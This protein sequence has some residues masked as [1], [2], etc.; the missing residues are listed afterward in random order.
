MISRKNAFYHWLMSVPSTLTIP[1]LIRTRWCSGWSL[2][3]CCG[4]IQECRGPRTG[5]SINSFLEGK[6]L[7]KVQMS[8]KRSLIWIASNSQAW[9]KGF[10]FFWVDWQVL[11][12]C[13]DKLE[14]KIN[15]IMLSERI[16]GGIKTHVFASS[17]VC[18]IQMKEQIWRQKSGGIASTIR[19][20]FKKKSWQFEHFKYHTQ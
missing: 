7:L 8:C 1:H 18:L 15:L 19:T 12:H 9:S 20:N 11:T 10:F 5:C 4:S 2:Q 14:K 16:L 17:F 6:K 3:G 13:S